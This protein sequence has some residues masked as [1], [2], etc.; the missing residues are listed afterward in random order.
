MSD[1]QRPISSGNRG[2]TQQ[3]LAIDSRDYKHFNVGSSYAGVVLRVYPADNLHTL[4]AQADPAHHGVFAECSVLCV[5]TNS[6]TL[7]K[8]DHVLIP[9]NGPSGL[10]S[11]HESL[12]RPS[13]NV[14]D[15][16][17]YDENLAS[18]DPNK[19]DGDWCI[20]NFLGSN[21]TKPY[22]AS[23]WQHP[24]NNLDSSTSGAGHPDSSGNPRALD[25]SGRVFDRVNGVEYITTKEGDL[26]VSTEF[27][28]SQL[29]YSETR[30]P[31]RGS[32]DKTTD[33]NLGGS[34]Q[35]RVKQSQT[36]EL[37]WNPSVEGLGIN[38][39]AD[40]NLP[41]KNP[42]GTQQQPQ[43]ATNTT[44]FI[45]KD[46]ALVTV[47]TLMKLKTKQTFKVESD[48]NVGISA[49]NELELESSS[50]KLGSDADQSLIRGEDLLAWLSNLT[51]LTATGPAKINPANITSFTNP[52]T[53]DAVQSTK[54][55]TK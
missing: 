18:L 35:V 36:L 13:S 14:I 4:G 7:L 9:P 53:G 54:V 2:T 23:W 3:S 42:P 34:I 31:V 22:I 43:E 50:I 33:E 17:D 52:T 25:Q 6:G 1:N 15:G 20:V 8:L 21:L 30:T 46:D 38:N 39:G 28:N 26:Y 41:Q 51:V 55:T 11:Y 44:V 48:D 10:Y 40:P 27:A 16:S 32:W 37:D 49:T 47:P 24:Y 19:L 12:P 29:N 45:S 5:G